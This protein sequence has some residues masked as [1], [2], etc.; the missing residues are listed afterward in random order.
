MCLQELALELAVWLAQLV[1]ALA[2]PTHVR[3]CVPEVRVR[4]PERL[5]STLASIPPGW[6]E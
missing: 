1:K 6:V 3:S 2:A 5:G 4:S